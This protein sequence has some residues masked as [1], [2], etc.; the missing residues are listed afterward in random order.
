MDSVSDKIIEAGLARLEF[1]KIEQ[2]R[3][4]KE[5]DI[6]IRDLQASCSHPEELIVEGEYHVPDWS[7][8]AD[9]PFR[10]CRRCGYSEPGWNCGF[11]RLAPNNHNIPHMSRDEALKFIRGGLMTQEEKMRLFHARWDRETEARQRESEEAAV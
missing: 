4:D 3:I 2:Q 8:R 7:N 11:F 10:V 5:I 9:P 6:L 1:L